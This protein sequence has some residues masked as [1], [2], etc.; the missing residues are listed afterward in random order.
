MAFLSLTKRSLRHPLARCPGQCWQQD[1]RYA[2]E[3][4]QESDCTVN[5]ARSFYAACPLN[6]LLRFRVTLYHHRSVQACRPGFVSGS[7]PRPPSTVTALFDVSRRPLDLASS[8]NTG[9]RRVMSRNVWTTKEMSTISP[10]LPYPRF[11]YDKPRLITSVLSCY[12]RYIHYL[13]GRLTSLSVCM[14]DPFATLAPLSMK[15]R[16]VRTKFFTTKPRGSR[17][18]LS[19]LGDVLLQGLLHL[20]PSGHPRWH[21]S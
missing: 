8:C 6:P 20:E 16:R 17:Q 14:R 2:L 7:S 18:I 9:L 10:V 3:T 13:A 1:C 11:P 21:Y 15:S 19:H 12:S 4:P 5:E